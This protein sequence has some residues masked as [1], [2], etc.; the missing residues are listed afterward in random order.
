MTTDYAREDRRIV[1]RMY[2]RRL[3]RKLLYPALILTGL[4]LGAMWAQ[5]MIHGWL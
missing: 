4:G 5:A 2:Q 3:R 1:L